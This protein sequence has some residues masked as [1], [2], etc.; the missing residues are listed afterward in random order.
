METALATLL[1]ILTEYFDSIAKNY[2]RVLFVDFSRACNTF[3]PPTLANTMVDLNINNNVISCVSC[4]LDQRQQ[5]VRCSAMSSKKVATSTGSPE[6]CVL[7]L[8]IFSLYV[9]A[10]FVQHGGGYPH[11]NFGCT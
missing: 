8:V 10:M 3:D 1:N 5:T 7:S 9:R 6:G 4:F 11:G 2:L